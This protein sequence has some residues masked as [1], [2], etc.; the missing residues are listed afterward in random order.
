MEVAGIQRLQF[1]Y[2][3]AGFCGDGFETGEFIATRYLDPTVPDDGAFEFG[4]HSLSTELLG[5][6]AIQTKL[7]RLGNNLLH[8]VRNVVLTFVHEKM[9]RDALRIG[10]V[11]LRKRKAGQGGH[12]EP[13]NGHR[14]G[15]GQ[16]RQ[17]N[18]NDFFSAI[19]WSRSMVV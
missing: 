13:A 17:I 6:R 15:I 2:W 7:P 1:F 18:D 5:K 8:T 19:A 11:S 16:I 14:S 10:L 3:S 4:V 12:E 9:E